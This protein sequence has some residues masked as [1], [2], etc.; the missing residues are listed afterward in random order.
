MVRD[1]PPKSTD[2]KISISILMRRE[3]S[4]NLTHS[5]RLWGQLQVLG[6]QPSRYHSAGSSARPAPRQTTGPTSSSIPRCKARL[7][8]APS[9]FTGTSLTCSEVFTSGTHVELH[10]H[11]YMFF[12]LSL[13][14][15]TLYII[16]LYDSAD[17]I[18]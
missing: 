8:L 3:S 9:P 5:L 1:Y 12:S 15:S 6:V 18:H 14:S 2:R 11:F 4:K 10:P 16:P 13:P 7:W 17:L